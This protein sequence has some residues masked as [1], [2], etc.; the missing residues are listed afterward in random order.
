MASSNQ[1]YSTPVKRD[2]QGKLREVNEEIL[3]V[4]SKR[5]ETLRLKEEVRSRRDKLIQEIELLEKRLKR[6]QNYAKNV[7]LPCTV[8]AMCK[9]V[10]INEELLKLECLQREKRDTVVALSLPLTKDAETETD[11]CLLAFSQA[12][13]DADR[14]AVVPFDSSRPSTSTSTQEQST[15][16]QEPSTST[17]EQSTSNRE[18]STSTSNQ[19]PSSVVTR[20]SPREKKSDTVNST[21]QLPALSEP[22]S[23]RPAP[24]ISKNAEA[25]IKGIIRDEFKKKIVRLAASSS[26]DSAVSRKRVLAALG[27]RLSAPGP[28]TAKKSSS[29]ISR[30]QWMAHR[31][32][33]VAR[34]AQLNLAPRPVSVPPTVPTVVR[35]VPVLLPMPVTVGQPVTVQGSGPPA[36]QPPIASSSRKSLDFRSNETRAAYQSPAAVIPSSTLTVDDVSF[37][38]VPDRDEDDMV[39]RNNKVILLRA[40]CKGCLEMFPVHTEFLR[41]QFIIHCVKRC[42]KYEKSNLISSCPHCALKLIN[43][44]ALDL[45]LKEVHKKDST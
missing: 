29:G 15:S 37:E 26:A 2:L 41:K 45:H 13:T 17:Q 5:I 6:D 23:D 11:D 1:A 38:Y 10:K 39:T 30:A 21:N 32:A 25:M 22:S 8:D 19:E 20:T 36:S 24:R 43:F 42:S 18:P 7:H 9:N 35:S 31:T 16:N 27:P 4:E 14:V 44:Q 34:Q 28:G 33:Y 12:T 3:L 40:K